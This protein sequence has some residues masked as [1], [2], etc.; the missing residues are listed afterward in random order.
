MVKLR[1]IQLSNFLPIIVYISLNKVK[2][3]VAI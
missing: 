3:S 2:A 1:Q